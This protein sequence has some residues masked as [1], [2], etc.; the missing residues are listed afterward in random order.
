MEVPLLPVALE[1][2]CGS[3]E[4]LW[5]ARRALPRMALLGT[6]R[7]LSFTWTPDGRGIVAVPT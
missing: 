4:A 1:A 7:P 2:V 3:G 5:D 6:G